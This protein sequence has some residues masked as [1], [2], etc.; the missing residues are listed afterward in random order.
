MTQPAV[1]FQ[2]KQLEEHFN[3]RLLERGYGGVS[4]TEAGKVVLDYA[5]RILDMSQELEARMAELSNELGGTLS[6]G[7][8]TTIAA[9]W[10]PKL[11]EGFCR[12]YPNVVPRVVVGPSQLTEDRVV[13][14]DL[15]IGLIEI[16]TDQSLL[17]CSHVAS[18]ELFVV[19][20]K[21][22]PLAGEAAVTAQQLQSLPFITRDTGNAI[23]VLAEQFFVASGVPVSSLNIRAELGSLSTVLHL[24]ACGQGFAI[25]S[26]AALG[27]KVVEQQLVAVS[28]SPKL[29]TPLH[30]I[31]PRDKFRS[32]LISAFTDYVT[33]A[34]PEIEQEHA[35]LRTAA[36]QG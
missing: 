21:D 35:R 6:L 26:G 18:D 2:V 4:L 5:E 15:D 19:L 36:T 14:R 33:Q 10:L 9:C 1:T 30:L 8:S 32:R 16:S 31:V 29:Y 24:A 27:R 17:E 34:A 25:A 23:R 3:T 12:Q 11:L 7:V 13:A 22:H 20:A 28:L